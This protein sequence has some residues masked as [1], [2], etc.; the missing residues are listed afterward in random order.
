MKLKNVLSVA[1]GR[2]LTGEE[3][4]V[5]DVPS[6]FASDM[7][8]EVLRYSSRGALLVTGNTNIQSL[9]TALIAEL[10][11]ILFV[12]NKTPGAETVQ[13]AGENGIFIGI[14]PLDTFEVCGRIYGL[15]KG[16]EGAKAE[17]REQGYAA[18]ERK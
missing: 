7:M 5:R 9:R 6:F 11:G 15:M 12:R 1:G 18:R 13:L 17:G 16:A 4:L 2:V 8:S 3:L 10:T 14:T